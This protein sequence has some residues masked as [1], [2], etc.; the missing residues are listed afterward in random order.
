MRPF[1]YRN[2]ILGCAVLALVFV[3]IAATPWG[4]TASNSSPWEA[5]LQPAQPESEPLLR[6]GKQAYQTNCFICHGKTGDGQG[7]AS[8]LMRNKPRNFTAGKFKLRTT[9]WGTLPTDED[10]FRTISLGFPQYGM[11]SFK[12]LSAKERWGLVYY[13]KTLMR[14]SGRKQGHPIELGPEP[15][16]TKESIAKGQD[17]Y[18]KFGCAACHG[19]EGRGDGPLVRYFPKTFEENGASTLPRDFTKGSRYM[20]SGGSPRDIARTLATGFEGS[21]M[22]SYLPALENPKDPGPLWG[23][24]HYVHQLARKEEASP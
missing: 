12:T 13:L 5:G 24:A 15:P 1:R 16:I 9:P 8:R 19:V 10:L 7:S 4:A 3:F 21:R 18:E 2:F 17:L 20:K 11:P 22:V 6:M 14:D 23:L